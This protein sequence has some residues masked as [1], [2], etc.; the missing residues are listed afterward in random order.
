MT[1]DI[2]IRVSMKQSLCSTLKGFGRN[3]NMCFTAAGSLAQGENY[4]ATK[5]SPNC[6]S[7]RTVFFGT[8]DATEMRSSHVIM[9]S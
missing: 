9:E 4:L 3:S 1:T 6:R 8:K 7:H 5:L 2:V